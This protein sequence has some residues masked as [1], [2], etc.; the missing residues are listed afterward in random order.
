MRYSKRYIFFTVVIAAALVLKFNNFKQLS[1]E[2]GSFR[3]AALEPADWNPLIAES[4]NEKPLKVSI[5]NKVYTNEANGIYMDENL[6]LMLPTDILRDSYNCSVHLYE[7]KRL[8]IEKYADVLTM[9]LDEPVLC[10]NDEENSMTSA[11][12]RVGDTYYVPAEMLSKNMGYTYNWNVDLNEAV[13]VNSSDAVGILPSHYDLRERQRSPK[14]KNQ[15]D[16]GTCWA[17]ASLAALESAML[18]EEHEIFSTD[19]MS[20]ENSFGLGQNDGGEYTMSLAY[21]VSWQGPVLEEDDPYDGVGVEGLEAVRHVQ[22]A[23]VIESKDFEKIKQAV[24]QYGAVQTSIYSSLQNVHS[25]SEFFNRKTNAYCYIGS[26]KPNHD[27][28]IIGWDDNFSRKNFTVDLEGDGAF[29][30]QNSWGQAFGDDGI[31]Y[32]SYYDNNIGIHNLVYTGVEDVNNYDRIYQSDLCGWVGQLGY[33]RDTAYGANVYQAIDNETLQAVGFYA[34]GKNTE[35]EIYVVQG[36]TEEKDLAQGTLCASGKV[37]NAGYYT[38]RLDKKISLN[39][40]EKFAIVLKVTTPDSLH[41][42]AI[43]YTADEGTKN[44]DLTDG[45]GY[46]SSFGKKWERVEKT[47]KSNL[48]LKAY[49]DER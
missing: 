19:H 1:E 20:L 24:F 16:K 10:V 32:V 30:C 35:Y 49:T 40:K 47:Q 33:N 13:V 18:P 23:Q 44:V 29:I 22:E 5:D 37:D 15:E 38:I 43:E 12:T 31:F 11:F 14:V 7:G 8:M 41:P 28:V 2:I 3:G 48:C 21:L 4:V 17:A 6:N 46:I 39:K 36:F 26:E 45:E 9:T 27:V 42:L 25:Q 34:T